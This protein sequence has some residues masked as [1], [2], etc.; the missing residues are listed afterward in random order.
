M[1]HGEQT[2]AVVDT[3]RPAGALVMSAEDL[4]SLPRTIP[5]APPERLAYSL[6]AF[7]DAVCLSITTVRHAVAAGELVTSLP[8]PAGKK[9]IIA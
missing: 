9:L 1:L 8:T 6:Q 5:V 3:V 4:F 7:A 2:L